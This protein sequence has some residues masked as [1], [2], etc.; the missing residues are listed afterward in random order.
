MVESK[1]SKVRKKIRVTLEENTNTT[2]TDLLDD[3]AEGIRDE[4]QSEIRIDVKT[5]VIRRGEEMLDIDGDLCRNQWGS[6]RIE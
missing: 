4:L 3:A 1:N 2:T 5:I 6:R